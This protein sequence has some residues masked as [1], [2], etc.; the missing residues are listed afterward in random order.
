MEAIE[1]LFGLLSKNRCVLQIEIWSTPEEEMPRRLALL[2][3]LFARYGIKF[4]RVIFTDH[5]FVSQPRA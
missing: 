5:F 3:T 1:G 2:E 4:V